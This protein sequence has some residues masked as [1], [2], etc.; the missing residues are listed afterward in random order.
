VGTPVVATR[1]TAEL[2]QAQAGR[3]LLV[4]DSP[5]EFAS[6]CLRLAQDAALGRRLAKAGQA[7]ARKEYDWSRNARVIEKS[8][9]AA[10]K[11]EGAR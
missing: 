5:E 9:V 1:V 8:W 11:K 2:A 7:L 3:H 4:A 6:A 10:L